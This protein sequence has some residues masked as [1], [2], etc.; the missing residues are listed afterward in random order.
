MINKVLIFALSNI[1][2]M[3]K[4][5]SEPKETASLDV[6][7]WF[8]QFMYW[9]GF[10]RNLWWLGRKTTKL[11]RPAFRKLANVILHSEYGVEE[12]YTSKYSE[13][14]PIIPMALFRCL[15]HVL[16]DVPLG[17]RVK[18]VWRRAV[19]IRSPAFPYIVD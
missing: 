19:K 11:I 12:R 1:A 7:S 4:Q 18:Y 3:K 8:F 13:M 15:P 5:K 10:I 6:I 9:L 16:R 17:V 14:V 2:F